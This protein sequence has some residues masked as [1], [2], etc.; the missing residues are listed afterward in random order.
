MVDRKHNC[1]SKHNYPAPT[2]HR[3]PTQS[4]LVEGGQVGAGRPAAAVLAFVE[5]LASLARRRLCSPF[6]NNHVGEQHRDLLVLGRCR[7]SRNRRAALVAE[8][9]VRRQ[10]RATRPAHQGGSRHLTRPPHWRSRHYRVTAGRPACAIS[11]LRSGQRVA[12]HAAPRGV[13]VWVGFRRCGS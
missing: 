5:D 12:R 9:R 1:R 8:L 2:H 6:M 7:G 3:D 10:L 13:G 11:P 4:M